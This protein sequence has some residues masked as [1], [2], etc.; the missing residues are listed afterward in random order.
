MY[1]RIPFLLA[2]RF[3]V[4]RF[5]MPFEGFKG[6]SF[7]ITLATV[8]IIYETDPLVRNMTKIVCLR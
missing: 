3:A 6:L 7:V 4:V 5:E 8:G 1:H 2:L